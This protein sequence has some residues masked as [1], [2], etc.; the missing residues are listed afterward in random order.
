MSQTLQGKLALERCDYAC[1][2][3]QHRRG[4]MVNVFYVYPNY[5]HGAGGSHHILHRKVD[6]I[7]AII[8]LCARCHTD[9]HNGRSPNKQELAELM[10]E[11]YGYNLWELWPQYINPRAE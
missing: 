8:G 6:D 7:R 5:F 9:Y 2:W 11:V 10:L 4:L 1:E 3:C